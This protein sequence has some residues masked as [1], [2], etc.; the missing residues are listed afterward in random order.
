[1]SVL[2]R[3]RKPGGFLQLLQLVETS[4]PAKQEKLLQAIRNED[5]DWADLV[6]NKMINPDMVFS[7]DDETLTLIF[8]S[9]LSR[10]SAIL[11]KIQ[12]DEFTGRVKNMMRAEKFKDIRD[13]LEHMADPLEAEVISAKNHMLETVRKMDEEKVILLRRID[14]NL[15]L[16]D[17]A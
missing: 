4:Q 15:D 5:P 13:I 10:H 2:N 16:S 7:W 9:M 8:E 1:M 3:Y 17:A 6:E 12:G 14:P 11:F